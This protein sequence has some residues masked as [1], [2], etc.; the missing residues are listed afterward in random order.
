M[1]VLWQWDHDRTYQPP[2]SKFNPN[3]R[4]SCQGTMRVCINN[5]INQPTSNVL[6]QCYVLSVWKS[7]ELGQKWE[8]TQLNPKQNK[9]INTDKWICA[10]TYEEKWVLA[11]SDLNPNTSGSSLQR[12]K[13][14]KS[15]LQQ[16]WTNQMLGINRIHVWAIQFFYS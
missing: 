8:L 4:K 3:L 6:T 10:N 15:L 5:Y 16:V 1:T 2:V 11:C 14:D 13:A 9:C 12:H 7:S